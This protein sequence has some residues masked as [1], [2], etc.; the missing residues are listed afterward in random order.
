[1]RA[2]PGV[3]SAREDFGEFFGR[4]YVRLARGLPAPDRESGGGRRHR[5]GR[6]GPRLRPVGRGRVDGLA[7]G[8]SVPDRVEPQ[9]QETPSSGRSRSPPE[10]SGRAAGRDRGG[11]G[12]AGHAPSGAGPAAGAARGTGAPGVA[13][14]GR[15]DSRAGEQF[16]ARVREAD[17]FDCVWDTR[18]D[19]IAPDSARGSCSRTTTSSATLRWGTRWTRSLWPRTRLLTCT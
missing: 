9:P 12:A 4:E 10:V 5:P 6:A 19:E 1:M 3:T 15:R 7:G 16:F 18:Q 2:F 17:W 13:R 8:L 11:R 14:P